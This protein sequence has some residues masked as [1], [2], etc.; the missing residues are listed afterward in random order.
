MLRS[1]NAKGRGELE[2]ER[3]QRVERMR[4]RNC[5][6]RVNSFLRKTLPLAPR[7]AVE[8]SFPTR[9]KA[10]QPLTWRPG[11]TSHTAGV[12]VSECEEGEPPREE[13]IAAH[14]SAPLHLHRK[15]R[16]SP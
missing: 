16:P 14:G 8:K 4:K 13:R 5:C 9:T 11:P 12:R 6:T 7:D 15:Q 1:A 2:G 3:A 10:T